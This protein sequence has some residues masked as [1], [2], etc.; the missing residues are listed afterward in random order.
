MF[1]S[2]KYT[3]LAAAALITALPCQAQVNIPQLRY[4]N[5][6]TYALWTEESYYSSPVVTDL[7]NDGSN[8]IIF[9]NYSITV[10]D[11][12]S[13][14]VEWRV[15]S[16]KD[17]SSQFV[18]LGGN[19]G[20]TWSD[21]EVTDIDGDGI[22]EI[23]S[24]HGHGIVSVLD[25]NG[26]FKYGWPQR[27]VYDSIRSLHVDDINNDGLNEIIVGA[28]VKSPLSVWVYNC[29]GSVM[30]GWPQMDNYNYAGTSNKGY[31]DTGWSYG[32]FMDAIT[33]G[34]V[35]NDGAKEIVVPTDTSFVAVY[36][37]N[38]SLVRA[39][40]E[41]YGG[42]MWAKIPFYESVESE[43][44]LDNEGWG[45]PIT[46]NELREELYAAEFGHAKAA[47]V[48]LDYDGKNEVVV[49]GIMANRKYRPV[50]PP[51]EYMT[52][53]ITNGDRTRYTN[54]ALGYDW[55]TIPTDLGA[56]LVQNPKTLSSMVQQE[57]IVSDLDGDGKYEILFASYNG[58]V[59][60]FALNKKAPGAW[61]FSLT[62]RSSPMFEY[63]S[64]P[65]CV[66]LD[67]DGKKEVIFT[68]FYD[69]TQYLTPDNTGYLY[70]VDCYGTLI[71]KTPLPRAKENSMPN[72][73]M[74]S[75]VVADIDSNGDWEIVINT[76]NGA[77]CVFD[78]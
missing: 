21:I 61:P 56:P 5:G 13:G 23:I 32:V 15:N 27:P 28:G 70:I 25:C 73:A 43:I 55:T 7:D 69:D 45:N 36:E 35:D 26:Y 44:R 31:T 76:L 50:Y 71:S 46:G 14:S 53:F 65:V 66:D 12:S 22:K 47:V 6:G 8:E 72:G 57:P 67:W 30:P 39:N 20:H 64:S 63:A 38:G 48:D 2:L 41:L 33:T 68:S 58:K 74:S 4:S 18:E 59:E 37:A 40:E 52:L 75:P 62:K 10:L 17:R 49:T 78:I 3:V 11:A 54:K 29:Y 77:I 60:C 24:T 51:T 34:D 42:R 19:D 16:G 9:S 1:K